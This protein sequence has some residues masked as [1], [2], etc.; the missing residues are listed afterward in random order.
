MYSWCQRGCHRR[1]PNS[2]HV[3]WVSR[4]RPLGSRFLSC[5]KVFSSQEAQQEKRHPGGWTPAGVPSMFCPRTHWPLNWTWQIVRAKG[6]AQHVLRTSLASEAGTWT[7]CGL[8]ALLCS[9]RLSLL[10]SFPLPLPRRPSLH[11]STVSHSP[12]SPGC[13]GAVPTLPHCSLHRNHPALPEHPTSSKH[14]VHIRGAPPRH[15]NVGL[16][17][18]PLS[19][20][21]FLFLCS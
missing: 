10:L 18:C 17:R 8:L 16:A 12:L 21:G 13:L 4:W 2:P 19:D 6:Q 14:P 9:Q 5:F 7:P 15:V 3:S 1:T 20:M 11:T